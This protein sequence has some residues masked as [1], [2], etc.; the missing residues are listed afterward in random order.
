MFFEISKETVS[1]WEN[2]ITPITC[3]VILGFKVKSQSFD[4][5]TKYLQP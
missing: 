5:S 2:S 4:S 3:K 1:I